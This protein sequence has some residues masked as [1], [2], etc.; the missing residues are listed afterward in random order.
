MSRFPRVSPVRIVFIVAI[1]LVV[2][3]NYQLSTYMN[4]EETRVSLQHRPQQ[5]HRQP[6]T[7]LKLPTPIFVVGFPKAGTSSIHAMF[8]CNGVRSSHYCCCGSNRT[9]THCNDGGRS[10]AECMR[11]NIKQKRPILKDCGDYTVYAQMDAEVG[12]STYE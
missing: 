11:D 2:I 12:N 9:H 6:P 5:A 10:F 3:F 7:V 4:V 8:Q 1:L